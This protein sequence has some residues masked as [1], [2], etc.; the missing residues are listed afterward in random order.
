M[1]SEILDKIP[2]QPHPTALM[3]DLHIRP[4]SA[5]AHEFEHLLAEASAIARPKAIYRLAFIDEKGQDR[6]MIEGRVF[7]SRV[8]RVNLETAQRVFAYAT[9]CGSELDEWS[10]GV[11]DM[12][13]R[14]WADAIKEV[15][16]YS[17]RGFLTAHLD[18]RYAV[19]DLAEMNP[20]SL[21]DWPIQEQAVLFDLLGDTQAAIGLSLTPSFLMVPTKS[22]SGL[23]FP[24]AESFQSCQLCPR[25]VCPNRRAPYDPD[26]WERKYQISLR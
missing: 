5:Y 4:G 2:F 12:L 21:E 8:L 3:Q 7:T 16:L 20:G 24:L 18:G 6:V 1:E 23:R 17:A 22:V 10:H 25:P 19:P 13:Y 11:E 26:L 9:T 15:A 14:F